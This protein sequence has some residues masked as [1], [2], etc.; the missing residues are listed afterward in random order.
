MMTAAPW[1]SA[2][3]SA[4]RRAARVEVLGDDEDAAIGHVAQP[5]LDIGSLETWQSLI[6]FRLAQRGRAH[7]WVAQQRRVPD[8]GLAKGDHDTVALRVVT[9]AAHQLDRRASL[10]KGQRRSRT[11]RPPG[12]SSPSGSGR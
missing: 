5:K 2:A 6:G 1:N 11:P 3:V 10:P 8:A 4:S 7:R 12:A 9:D